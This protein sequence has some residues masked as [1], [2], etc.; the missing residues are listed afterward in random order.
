MTIAMVTVAPCP[1]GLDCEQGRCVGRMTCFEASCLYD[2][3]QAIA[4]V[5][6]ALTEWQATEPAEL[7]KAE[8]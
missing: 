3:K 7:F 8:D 2:N 4:R 6:E 1:V 5:H